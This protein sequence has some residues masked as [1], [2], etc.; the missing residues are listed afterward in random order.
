MSL[1]MDAVL[2]SSY[3]SIAILFARDQRAVNIPQRSVYINPTLSETKT[4][5]AVVS[6]VQV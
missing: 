4:S 5:E 6:V 3:L 2:I 1:R